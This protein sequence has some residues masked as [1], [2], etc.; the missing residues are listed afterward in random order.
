MTSL[1]QVRQMQQQGMSETDIVQ[2]LQSQGVSYREISEALSQ[3]KIKA[4]VEQPAL[5]VPSMP[6]STASTGPDQNAPPQPP[7]E[8]EAPMPDP[9]L[10]P[11]APPQPPQEMEQGMQQSMLQPQNSEYDQGIQ[12]Y[13]PTPQEQDQY[14]DPYGQSAYGDYQSYGYG[15]GISPDTISEI[16]EQIVSEKL[17]EIRKHLEN[18]ADFKTTVEAKT[19]ALEDRL[20]RIEKIIDT[21]QTSVLRKIGNYVTNID[22][23]KKELVATQ[24]SFAKLV[25]GMKKRSSSSTTTRRKRTKKK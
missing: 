21:L 16:S 2:S 25:P 15:G 19:E 11:N 7:Q 17:M 8:M 4:A 23:I 9:G 22:D 18:I 24:K 13:S 12:E 1:D 10:D 14:Q 20:K 3:S 5:E 6:G